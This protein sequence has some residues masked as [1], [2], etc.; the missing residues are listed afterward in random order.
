M[1]AYVALAETAAAGDRPL[2]VRAVARAVGT[3]ATTLYKYGLEREVHAAAERQRRHADASPARQE[4]LG[5]DARLV[6]LRRELE[7]METRNRALL[8]RIAVME[9]NAA[10]LG[11]D[12]EELHR[13]GPKPD[14]RASRA[15]S[16]GRGPRRP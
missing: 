15:G 11:V 4:K 16:R 5:Y 2:D 13:A 14:R 6:A 12:P 3:S 8:G 10:R 1:R 7:A 9:A